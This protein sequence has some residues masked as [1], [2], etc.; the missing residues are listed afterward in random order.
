MQFTGF[1]SYIQILLDWVA[2]LPSALVWFFF[3]FS[4]LTENVFP[5]WPGDTVT[6]FGGFLLARGSIGFWELTT[7]TLFGNLAGAWLMYS[8][9]HKVLDWL[10][11]KEFP[12]KSELYDEESIQKTLDWF[13]RNSVL[14]VIFSRFS[15]GIRFFV[16]IVAGMTE[17]R[18]AIFFSYFSIAVLLWCGILIYGGFYLGSHWEKVLEFLSLYNRIATTT[19]ILVVLGFIIY[20][21]RIEKKKS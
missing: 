17:M 2:G 11:T 5:P 3:A 12:F 18:P 6:V 13:S 21:K 1:D 15:A 14:V 10:K 9:G 4:N 8:F 19:L 7:S 20:K 16:S